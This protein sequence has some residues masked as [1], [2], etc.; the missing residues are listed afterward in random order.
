M[1]SASL[2]IPG[3]FGGLA[4]APKPH[5]VRCEACGDFGTLVIGGGAR[6]QPHTMPNIMRTELPCTCVAG[7]FWREF[8]A[9]WN[10]PMRP[11]G[12]VRP[13][14]AVLDEPY[15]RPEPIPGPQAVKGAA[16]RMLALIGG[17]K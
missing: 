9:E 3:K 12:A 11:K 1:D 13:A 16:Q 14:A 8:F 2:T 17:R 6:V 7:D 10:L 15:K 5:V 4:A